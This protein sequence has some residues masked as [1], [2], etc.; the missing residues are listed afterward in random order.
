MLNLSIF[1]EFQRIITYCC[2]G[3][4]FRNFRIWS[5]STWRRNRQRS[6]SSPTCGPSST[7]PQT[8]TSTPPASSSSLSPPPENTFTAWTHCLFTA[9]SCSVFMNQNRGKCTGLCS[10]VHNFIMFSVHD[11]WPLS[12]SM[13]M[14]YSKLIMFS[15]HDIPYCTVFMNQNRL[16]LSE[17]K[18]MSDLLC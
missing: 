8:C 15:V 4:Y 3:W 6:S 16:F 14:V 12:C 1:Q 13:F 2:F 9:S 10:A 11:I 7:T 5:L 18:L 17:N